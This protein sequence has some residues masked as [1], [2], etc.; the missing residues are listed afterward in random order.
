MYNYCDVH[1]AYIYN[2]TTEWGSHLRAFTAMVAPAPFYLDCTS[3]G[4]ERDTRR[5]LSGNHTFEMIYKES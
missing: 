2:L 3:P 5:E 1:D 4:R